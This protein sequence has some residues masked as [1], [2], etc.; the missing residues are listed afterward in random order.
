MKEY[1]DY[2][3]GISA[4]SEYSK[5]SDEVFVIMQIGNTEMD[6]IWKKVYK[7]VIENDPIKYAA[8][9]I[10]KHNEG[11]LLNSEIADFIN[12]A[13]IV[14]A[15][16]TNERPN[17]YLEVGYTMGIRKF[18]NLILCAR[19]DHNT[20]N[21]NYKPGVGPK[22]HFDLS[23]YDILW[24]DKDNLVDFKDKL[25]RKI[26][27]RL[28][29]VNASIVI[30]NINS[31]EKSESDDLSDKEKELLISASKKGE[32]ILIEVDKGE[33]I[34]VNGVK[35]FQDDNDPAYAELFRD[36]FNSLIEKGYIRH[37]GGILYK[38]T[39]SGFELARKL[40]ND[41]KK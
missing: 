12:R 22:V 14:I 10:D 33:W 37:D 27:H 9:R 32:Y 7:P 24:W 39:G 30:N 26:Q 36:A 34:R 2:N 20:D 1:L 31:A 16:L 18:N 23:G 41:T 17:C 21:P 19:V 11:R 4:Q 6:D 5:L 13:K 38:L 29:I 28:S 3:T 15:D 40:A 35:D 25:I 8:K